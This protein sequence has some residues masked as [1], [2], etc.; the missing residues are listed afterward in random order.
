MMTKILFKNA[1]VVSSQG[2]EEKDVFVEDGVVSFVGDEIERDDVEVVDC[3]REGLYLLPGLID[4]HVH[5]RDPGLTE[6]GSWETE[7]AAALA[8]GV[9]TVFDMPNTKPA[10]VTAEAFRE[11]VERAQEACEC[12]FRLFMGVASS[13]LDEV[14]RVV[15]DSE[16]R[17]FLAGVKIFMGHSTGNMGSSGGV[18]EEVLAAEDLREVPV[19][20][21]AEEQGCLDSVSEVF[22]VNDP[23]SHSRARPVECAVKAVKE[24]CHLARKYE[25]SVHIAHVSSREELDVIAKFHGN[26]SRLVTCEVS[27]HH[28]FLNEDMYGELGHFLK[29]NPPVRS[30]EESASLW[31][32]VYGGG[33]DLIATDHSPH[34]REEKEGFSD[35][36]VPPSGMPEVQTLL[37]LL[38]NEVASD[39]LSLEDVVRLC[40]ENPAEVFVLKDRGFV[41]EG[42]RADLV[43]V[44]MG[45]KWEVREKD[46]KYKCGWSCYE[47]RVLK[48]GVE[49]VWRG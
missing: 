39:K 44:D 15:E 28:L 40:C 17:P 16:L 10:T 41:R 11:K 20:V 37:P 29:V 27:P 14:R 34:T 46:L 6:K 18:L 7:S 5:F 19:V 26:G 33:V 4:A 38:L 31:Q 32:G 35:G 47:G 30:R 9:T 22:D 23:A 8:G 21:H 48:G 1:R 43:L 2:I 36:D 12:D 45:M 13:G 49:G 3:S 42:M 24:A 25:R